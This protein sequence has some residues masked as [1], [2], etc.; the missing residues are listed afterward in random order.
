[1]RRKHLWL[2]HGGYWLYVFFITELINKLAYQHK[3]I[4]LTL[5]P[6]AL[7]ISNYI[8][9]CGIFY[10][11]YFLVLPAL[12]RKKKYLIT[13][14]CWILLTCLFVALRYLV[15]EYLFP[16]YLGICNYCYENKGI[17]VV[18]NFFQ[19]FSLLILAGTV[20]WFA[21]NWLSIEKQKLNLEQEKLKAERAF[22]QS[23]VNPHFLFNTLN[24]IYSMVFHH[25]TQALPAIQKLSEIM[26]YAT[27]ET[28]KD[29]VDLGVEI[30]CLK[31]YIDL[32]KY[33]VKDPAILYEQTGNPEGKRIAPMLLISFVENAFKHGII[34]DG[35]HPL[36]IRLHVE[37]G[38]LSFA[39][40]NKISKDQTDSSS[41]I[42]LTS[43]E[44][45]LQLFYPGRHDLL[46]DQTGEYFTSKMTIQL[47]I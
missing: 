32:Q 33:R 17:Y 8:L 4:R 15:Q 12:F 44:R 34:N 35:Q 18:N 23:Q 3:L 7:E 27:K 40:R 11:N 46:I 26:R 5:L 14:A 41:G 10:L 39:V 16:R 28:D 30:S 31:S 19:G 45:R 21:D 24:N 9:F 2:I 29:G 20:I 43:V 37:G 36:L 1:M 38:Q 6:D 47:G 25:S 42:G 13:F 22:L